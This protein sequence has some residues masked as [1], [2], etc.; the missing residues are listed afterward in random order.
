MP[1][2]P[3]PAQLPEQTE[4]IAEHADLGKGDVS[5][6]VVKGTVPHPDTGEPALNIEK[7]GLLKKSIVVPADRILDEESGRVV[8]DLDE[9]EVQ[10]LSSFGTSVIPPG[11]SEGKRDFLAGVVPDPVPKQESND[12][13]ATPAD[14]Y[15]WQ[16]I[17]EV[18]QAGTRPR[19][20]A[21]I[22]ATSGMV[23]A[24]AIFW[25]IMVATGATLGVHHQQVQTAQDAASALQPIAGPLAQYLFAAGL[26]ASALLVLP[27][28]AGTTAY[29][30]G[31][32]L[33]WPVGLSRQPWRSQ[34]FYIVLLA[35]LLVVT[36]LTFL[37]I[38]PITLLFVAGIIGGIGTPLLL[39]LMLVIAGDSRLYARPADR[40]QPETIGLE[41][42]G[43]CCAGHR[44]L[45]RNAVRL[46]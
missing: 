26:L 30:V 17:E 7:G 9:S 46:I 41:H 4:V 14:V 36:P 6:T 10:K 45:L 23:V 40:A 25:F 21:Q 3:D 37:N 13:E 16:T 11:P 12:R 19:R 22:D 35:T 39:A 44:C 15:Y 20:L 2:A 43:H 27:V 5:K 31:D 33:G 34:G 8:L 29:A 28:L 42:D 1:D 32:S 18:E 38:P 24:T